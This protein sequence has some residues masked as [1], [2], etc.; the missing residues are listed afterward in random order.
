MAWS[1]PVAFAT[2]EVPTVA[3]M[4]TIQDN[5]SYLHGDAGAVTINNDLT[6]PNLNAVG[7][8][9][10]ALV[11]QGTANGSF[12]RLSLIAKTAGGA[13]VDYRY[14][15]NALGGGE[16]VVYDNAAGATRMHMTSTGNVAIGSNA[17]AGKFHVQ[18]AGAVAGAGLIIGSVAGVF[19][20]QTVFAAGTVA[21]GALFLILDR[22]SGSVAPLGM[23]V[24]GPFAMTLS[25]SATYNPGGFDTITVSVTAGGAVTVQRTAGTHGTHDITVFAILT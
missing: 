8:A 4:N 7:A 25:G 10:A 18:A 19:S 1:A 11:A 12:A 17:P 13:A 23:A 20:L 24:G 16:W 22:D 14:L 3:K 2:L 9:N 6:A 15:T 21:R 5:L